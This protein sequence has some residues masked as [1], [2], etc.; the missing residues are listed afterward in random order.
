MSWARTCLL[1]LLACTRAS[2]D[3]A[4]ETA[5]RAEARRLTELGTAAYESGD[6][7]RAL[8][9]FEQAY[10]IY[11]SPKLRYNQGL[12]LQR[13]GRDLAA[14]AAFEAFLRDAA[15][16][17][18][19]ARAH[20]RAQLA[21]LERKLGAV[22][23]ESSQPGVELKLDGEKLAAGRRQR[24]VPGPHELAATRAGHATFSTRFEVAAGAVAR[25]TLLWPPAPPQVHEAP[26]K[27]RETPIVKRW[28]L[29]TIV[30]VVAAGAV[31]TTAGV[32][33][34]QP[35]RRGDGCEGA[36]GGGLGCIDLGGGR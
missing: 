24:V 26:A 23:V 20:A 31:A 4:P 16:A 29:W 28:W 30:G 10:L 18:E 9:Y 11:P 1:V 3:E 19:A 25:P 5:D 17:P 36:P 8:E 14:A 21:E 22:E 12:S 27:P 32:L 15:D 13:L 35:R 2:A 34:T 7:A 6:D 33:A